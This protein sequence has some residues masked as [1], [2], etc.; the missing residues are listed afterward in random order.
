M[1]TKS[2][3]GIAMKRTKIQYV[4]LIP[5]GTFQ[6]VYLVSEYK[7]NKIQ[8]VDLMQIK[9]LLYPTEKRKIFNMSIPEGTFQCRSHQLSQLGCEACSCI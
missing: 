8:W 3:V 4:E 9:S 5:G 1:E 7:E 2:L 6:K